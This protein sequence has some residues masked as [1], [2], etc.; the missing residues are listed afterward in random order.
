MVAEAP[1]VKICG[2]QRRADAELAAA[3]GVAYLGVVL[4]RGFR[5]SVGVAEAAAI[6]DGLAPT[7]V[8]VLVDEPPVAAAGLARAVGAGV[9]QLHGAETPEAAA[10]VAAAGGW[11]VWK[12]VRARAPADVL[13]AV[14]RYGAVVHGILVEGFAEGVVGGGG[15]RL[16]LL[17]FPP[18]PALIPEPLESILAGG[19]DPERVG[20]AVDHFRPGTV[21]VSSGV[22]RSPGGK[23]PD[24]L[25]RFVAAARGGSGGAPPPVPPRPTGAPE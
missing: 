14:E 7:R 3:L 20:A 6:L 12:A 4:T 22:E 25:R 15:A 18:L 10:E 19:L 5:R 23:D 9:V 8:A 13:R 2:L 24:L 16:S 21:D 11:R 17:D 1:R